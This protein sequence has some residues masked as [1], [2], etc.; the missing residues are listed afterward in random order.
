M[1]VCWSVCRSMV[2]QERTVTSRRQMRTACA[3]ELEGEASV[4]VVALTVTLTAVAA[5]CTGV[6]LYNS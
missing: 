4:T 5:V 1:Y 3:L 6:H 2:G